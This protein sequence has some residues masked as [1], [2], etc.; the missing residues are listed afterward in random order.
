MESV[1]VF[2]LFTFFYKFV[3][4]STVTVSISATKQLLAYASH[5]LNW[6]NC[7]Q[8]WLVIL[9]LRETG[10]ITAIG[11]QLFI[12]LLHYL[13]QKLNRLFFPWPKII[14]LNF[15]MGDA[16]L[17]GNTLKNQR[18]KVPCQAGS[19]YG[20]RFMAILCILYLETP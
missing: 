19:L 9:Y 11:R 12:P 17:P 1:A 4:E 7:R 8:V 18:T 16:L 10:T 15:Q 13:K 14:V 5:I 6:W 2:T 3:Q 20:M